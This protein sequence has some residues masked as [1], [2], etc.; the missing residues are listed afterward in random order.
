MIRVSGSTLYRTLRCPG[1]LTLDKIETDNVYAKKGRK[2]HELS[3]KC[4]ME[5]LET[6]A[7]VFDKKEYEEVYRYVIMAHP[8]LYRARMSKKDKIGIEEKFTLENLKNKDVLIEGTP[9]VW[10]YEHKLKRLTIIDF[11]TGKHPVE[12]ILNKQL[13]FY[14]FLVARE[15]GYY[16]DM[17]TL[18]LVIIQPKVSDKAQSY[19]LSTGTRLS[20]DWNFFLKNLNSLFKDHLKG[21]KVGDMFPV[22]DGDHCHFCPSMKFCSLKQTGFSSL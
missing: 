10:T 6:D 11:K 4:L 22:N 9:D 1:S 20:A 8:Y 18:D 5:Y 12:P 21:Y 17:E 7:S 2:L 14:G 16:Y 13:M 19:T 3:A 15:R